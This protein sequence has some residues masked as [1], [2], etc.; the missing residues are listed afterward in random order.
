MPR[1]LLTDLIVYPLKSAAGSHVASAEVDA[2]G[3]R[4]DRRWMVVTRDG[5]FVTQREVPRMCLLRP[6]IEGD[7]MR[8]DA[9]GMPSLDLPLAPTAEQMPEQRRVTIWDDEP[10]AR[11]APAEANR[12]I[13]EFYGAPHQLV[14]LPEEDARQVDPQYAQPG[15]KVGF[16]DGYPFLLANESSLDDLNTRLDEPLPMNRFRPNLVLRSDHPWEEDH[17]RLLQIGQ[18]RFNLVKPCARC[19]ITTV[20]QDNGRT[21]KEPLKTLATFR[22][23]GNK[24]MFGQNLT[25]D[26]R[27]WLNV[28]D[29]V[30]VLEVAQPLA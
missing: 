7:T 3:F 25:H 20:D 14:Y 18:I 26:G 15:D 4:R 21:A 27:G 10:L 1:L 6:T 13:S 5:R 29:V 24:V 30:E 11:V 16:A 17:W 19:P 2:C 12:W 8:L 28:G 23:V 9:P 22:R